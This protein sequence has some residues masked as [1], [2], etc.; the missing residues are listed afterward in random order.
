[1]GAVAPIIAIAATALSTV[2]GVAG[3]IQQGQAARKQA[4]YQAAVARNNRIIAERKAEDARERGAVE[5][6]QHRLMVAQRIGSQRAS[7]AGRGV[8]VDVGSAADLTADTAQFGELD[9][10]TIRSNAEREAQA[11]E[12]EGRGFEAEAGL[13]QL[14]GRTAERESFLEAGGTFLSG[15]SKVADRWYQLR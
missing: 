5:E 3:S 2:A 7:A 1:M 6:R 4:E 14:R 12:A 9:A 13:H 8:L 15:T 10:L 11:F